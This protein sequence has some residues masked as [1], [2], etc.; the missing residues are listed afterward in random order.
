[1]KTCPQCHKVL[2][3]DFCPDCGVQA[4]INDADVSM[5]EIKCPQCGKIIWKRSCIPQ[6]TKF[7][8]SC[9]Y[10]LLD[11]VFQVLKDEQSY[12]IKYTIANDALIKVENS[13]PAMN[14][15]Y[16][17]NAKFVYNIPNGV[18]SICCNAFRD[19]QLKRKFNAYSNLHEITSKIIIPKSVKFIQIDSIVPRC[20][21]DGS[22][23]PYRGLVYIY[24][25]NYYRDLCDILEIEEHK[26]RG[27]IYTGIGTF[28]KHYDDYK[29]CYEWVEPVSSNFNTKEILRRAG[30]E[31]DIKC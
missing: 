8:E 1:M 12:E 16:E 17:R 4:E 2:C 26:D 27:A 11:T 15:T 5:E 13:S 31:T 10:Q 28:E 3:G 20:W 23:V 24:C 22:N 19:V 29:K 9:G 25:E 7:C 6:I 21:N 14:R 18:K 30:V